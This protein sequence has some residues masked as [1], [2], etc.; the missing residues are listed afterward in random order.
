MDQQDTNK[1]N[2]I[3]IFITHKVSFGLLD[4]KAL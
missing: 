2:K 1:Y 4:A 3:N